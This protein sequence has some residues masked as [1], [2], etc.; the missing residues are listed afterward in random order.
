MPPEQAA[1]AHGRVGPRSDVYALGAVLYELV[2]GRP[3]FQGE[4]ALDTL[5]LVR[6]ADPVRPSLLNTRVPSD[7][8]TIC[9]KCLEKNPERRYDSAGAL[10]AELDRFLEG[11]P[12]VARPISSLRRAVRWC[13]R[14]PLPAGLMAAALVCS[15]VAAGFAAET[16]RAY[17]GASLALDAR[18]R[19]LRE[20]AYERDMARG[21]L[22]DAQVQRA[23]QAWQAGDLDGFDRLL[24]QVEPHGNEPDRRGWE[25]FYLR[26]LAHQERWSWNVHA[27]PVRAV[28]FRHDGVQM[29]SAGEDG[30]VLIWDV[31]EGRPV[32][33]LEGHT[34][35]VNGIAW[36]EDGARLASCGD[37]QSV[38][39]WDATRAR[40]LHNLR[41]DH[42]R[43]RSVA[44]SPDQTRLAVAGESGI[45]LC[46]AN[47]A[48]PPSRLL[49]S[50]SYGASVAWSP[51]GQFLATGADDHAVRLW[52]L[53]GPKVR[54]RTLG[55]HAGWVNALAWNR[56][57]TRLAT[58][59]QDG[60]LKVWDVATGREL[61]SRSRELSSAL[62]S[63][64][65]TGDRTS[66]VTSAADGTVTVWEASSGQ[67]L[68]TLRGHRGAVRTVCVS[69]TSQELASA[70]DDGS[71]KLW[72]RGGSDDGAV[73][74]D[75]PAPVKCV[76]WSPDGSALASM[77]LDGR[78]RVWWT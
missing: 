56:D 18:S 36:S 15:I 8:E 76:S 34:G 7:L 57:T 61:F 14:H 19:A 39:V 74:R 58:V 50:P 46:E 17:R 44:W 77:D 68:R 64:A 54:A 78:I 24:E 3:A 2:T 9:L 13:R 20:A 71:I 32:A 6:N 29:A 21:H 37:D 65:W 23:W 47:L 27:G 72:N 22:Y 38:R 62:L 52:E 51:N 75:D 35:A 28:A 12:I 40:L 69:P 41:L 45:D 48:Q 66:I 10:A 55:R 63:V 43:L 73:V 53:D 4:T 26:S 49:D 70:G 25:W 31:S 5:L 33:R 59:S 60:V 42:G 11:R 30:S 1:G 16:Y 67:R